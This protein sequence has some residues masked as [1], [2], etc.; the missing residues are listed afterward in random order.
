MMMFPWITSSSS[1]C[2]ER[3][4]KIAIGSF[5]LLPLGN[6]FLLPTELF[7]QIAIFVTLLMCTPIVAIKWSAEKNSTITFPNAI[8]A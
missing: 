7:Y 2:F 1:H 6:L 8:S 3:I 4:L 5:Y